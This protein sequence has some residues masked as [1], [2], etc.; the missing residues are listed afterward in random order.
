[1]CRVHL[2]RFVEWILPDRRAYKVTL[3]MSDTLQPRGLQPARLLCPWDSPG[4]N[5][6]VGCHALPQ[7][8]FPTQG[9]NLGFPHCRQILYQLSHHRT[10]DTGQAVPTPAKEADAH[11]HQTCHRLE[12]GLP[13][14][15]DSGEQVSAVDK[16][17]SLCYSI[18]ATLT[19][20]TISVVPAKPRILSPL[21]LRLVR[22]V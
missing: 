12:L 8:V 7:G 15:Q 17:S 20:K 22:N 18:P 14:L 10:Q 16:P 9:W 13:S 2:V 11:K 1:M 4:K 21:V 19:T 5:T 6:G 3:V